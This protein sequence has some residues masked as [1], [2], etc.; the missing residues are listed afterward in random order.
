MCFEDFNQKL[1]TY[2]CE[3]WNQNELIQLFLSENPKFK[4]YFE[5]QNTSQMKSIYE[6]LPLEN[7]F[8]VN[9]PPIFQYF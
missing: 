4:S 7:D 2:N 5:N 9:N 3:N 1:N 6:S 8:D